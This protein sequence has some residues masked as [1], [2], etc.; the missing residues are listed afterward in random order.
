MIGLFQGLFDTNT[1]TFNP[2]DVRAVQR[3]A[4]AR[5]I[6]FKLEAPAGTGPAAAFAFDPDG[7]PVL[8]DQH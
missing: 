5:G 3:D 4:K 1:I 6:A 8:L 7:N 2:A